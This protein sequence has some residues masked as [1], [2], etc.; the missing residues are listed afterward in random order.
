M[1]DFINDLLL[2]VEIAGQI[3]LKDLIVGVTKQERVTELLKQTGKVDIIIMNQNESIVVSKNNSQLLFNGPV[4]E[5]IEQNVQFMAGL[6]LIFSKAEQGV[7][8]RD[9]NGLLNMAPKDTSYMV[10]RLKETNLVDTLQL[11]P[12]PLISHVYFTP[13]NKLFQRYSNLQCASMNSSD[14][15]EFQKFA[16][17]EDPNIGM[18]RPTMCRVLEAMF[19][20]TTNNVLSRSEAVNILVNLT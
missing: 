13:K 7:L 17:E 16:S 10:K 20:E 19:D 11:F 8:Q 15:A 4:I 2:K 18:D 3:P 6:R 14:I 1:D 12:S 9:L 5:S